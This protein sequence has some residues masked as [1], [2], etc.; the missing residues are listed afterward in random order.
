MDVMGLPDPNDVAAYDERLAEITI[1]R[2]R[3]LSGRI[4]LC[5]YDPS[6]PEI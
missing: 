6:W 1:G 3:Q 5:D 4:E 2:P